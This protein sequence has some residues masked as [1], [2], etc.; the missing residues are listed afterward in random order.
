[1]AAL[2]SCFLFPADVRRSV[3]PHHAFFDMQGLTGER[4]AFGAVPGS[5]WS[6]DANASWELGV[7]ARARQLNFE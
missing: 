6:M 3:P 2:L 4:M 1:M 5:A 7:P